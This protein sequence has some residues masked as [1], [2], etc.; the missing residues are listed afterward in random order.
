MDG[1]DEPEITPGSIYDWRDY[2]KARDFELVP[3]YSHHTEN[4]L[5]VHSYGTDL[6]LNLSPYQFYCKRNGL[7]YESNK[8]NFEHVYFDNKHQLICLDMSTYNAEIVY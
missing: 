7:P 5:I 8:V 2:F 4:E 6:V 3:Q 1:D